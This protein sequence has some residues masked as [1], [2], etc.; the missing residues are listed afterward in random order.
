MSLP[1]L[2]RHWIPDSG[3]CT[4]SEQ[5]CFGFCEETVNKCS[6]FDLFTKR[7]E[8]YDIIFTFKNISLVMIYAHK[9]VLSASSDVFKAMCYGEMHSVEKVLKIE[10]CDFDLVILDIYLR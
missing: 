10:M 6:F 4:V 7:N 9:E 8:S 2:L 1:K 3:S 5:S